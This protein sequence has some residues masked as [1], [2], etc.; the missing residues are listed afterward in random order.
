MNISGF[1]KIICI[2][3]FEYQ[4]NI[5]KHESCSFAAFMKEQDM[6]CAM[7]M[8]DKDIE[9]SDDSFKFIGHVT[10]VEVS[11]DISGLY[12]EVKTI[13]KTYLYDQDRY[14]RVFQQS[15]KN[16]SDILS[17]M[18]SMSDIEVQVKDEPV[19]ENII[20]QNNETE[21]KFIRKLVNRFGLHIFGQEK[22]FIGKYGST[23]I[24]IQEDQLIDYKINASHKQS[25]MTCRID[26]SIDMGS[27]VTFS[28]K[29][30]YVASKKYILEKE[31]YY[32]EYKLFEIQDDTEIQKQEINSY[33]Y[34]KVTDNNDP[35]NMGRLQVIF[36]NDDIEDCMKDSPVWINRLDIYASKGL[37]PVYIPK[38]D[39][40]VRVHLYDGESVIVGCVR[41]EAYNA[42]YDKS[43]DKYFLID[44]DVF[45]QY[46][47]GKITLQNKDN[48]VE[49]SDEEII[50][51]AGDKAS[52]LTTKDRVLVQKD[53]SAIEITSDI[54]MSSGKMIVETKGEVSIKGTDVNIKGKSGVNIN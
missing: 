42:P 13:G 36:E 39:D 6:E 14:S 54:N 50:I 31:K 25:F 23:Q 20:F 43:D 17:H 5:D 16:I 24:E 10:D 37:G 46:G 47:E 52:I 12:I 7:S 21:W 33:L 9:F 32:Y 41:T 18:K 34:A 51:R 38:V 44:E 40:I 19:I 30:Y 29:Q 49:L 15:D 28:D 53:K 26:T 35:D 48:T 3:K 4:N 11:N 45:F 8:V 1:E 27:Q 2:D 22:P